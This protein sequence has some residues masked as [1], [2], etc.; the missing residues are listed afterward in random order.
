[1][2]PKSKASKIIDALGGTAKV[3][4]ICH[5]S[6]PAVSQWREDGIPEARLMYLKLKF[7][8]VFKA[9]A[10]EGIPEDPDESGNGA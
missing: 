10:K 1:M 4:K 3:A 5:V 7:P 8:S 2:N 6:D 9:L